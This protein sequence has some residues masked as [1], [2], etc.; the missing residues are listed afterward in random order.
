M[1]AQV[2]AA[3]IGIRDTFLPTETMCDFGEMDT[4]S[5]YKIHKVK[6][7]NKNAYYT[8]SSPLED[9]KEV[10]CVLLNDQCPLFLKNWTLRK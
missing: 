3:N 8:N 9:T 4:Q 5:V 1:I 2:I 10:D 7:R 6:I